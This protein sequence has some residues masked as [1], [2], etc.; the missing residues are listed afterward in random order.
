MTFLCTMGINSLCLPHITGWS[1]GSNKRIWRC[2]Q[3]YKTWYRCERGILIIIVGKLLILITDGYI[4]I[5]EWKNDDWMNER[6]EMSKPRIYWMIS[7]TRLCINC[8]GK[9]SWV[10]CGS[11]PQELSKVSPGIIQGVWQNA[12]VQVPP[13]TLCVRITQGQHHILYF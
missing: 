5:V 12:S 7:R 9:Q 10:K 2:F 4:V 11:C 6:M 3:N 1:W 8:L 13:Q